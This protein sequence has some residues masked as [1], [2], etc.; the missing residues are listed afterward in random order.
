MLNGDRPARVR[1]ELLAQT[2]RAV[3]TQND[4]SM[5]TFATSVDENRIRDVERLLW[6]GFNEVRQSCKCDGLL[7]L[8]VSAQVAR[9]FYVQGISALSRLIGNSARLREL[10]DFMSSTIAE[11]PDP[12]DFAEIIDVVTE[13]SRHLPLES[14]PLFGC[15][16]E[17]NDD[18]GA[19]KGIRRVMPAYRAVIRRVKPSNEGLT[20]RR[21]LAR[22]AASVRFFQHSHLYGM[23]KEKQ[24]LTDLQKSGKLSLDTVFPSRDL[25]SNPFWPELDVAETIMTKTSA[26]SSSHDESPPILCHFSCH[27]LQSESDSVLQMRAPF[28]AQ[29]RPYS[30]EKLRG[31]RTQLGA[32]LLA[33]D[34]VFLNTCRSAVADQGARTSAVDVL[35]YYQPRC[36]IGTLADLP[37]ATAATFSGY[38]YSE[39]FEGRSVGDALRAA[40]LRLL[41]E[42]HNPFGMLYTS[43]F[44]ED[45]AM[46]TAVD[47]ARIHIP[48]ELAAL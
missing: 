37:D 22:R 23:H 11:R 25:K 8:K 47:R 40:R 4:R 36:L 15:I 28:P 32:S 30:L 29:E 38:F 46:S 24:F 39:L 7:P 2:L 13:N 10:Q 6:K 19:L 9:G 16:G 43:Y 48:N 17:L 18:D 3:D 35:S 42:E 12:S 21:R 41:R 1:I 45:V 31:A 33:P 34:V 26:T 44:G 27:L 20:C 5:C 14:M